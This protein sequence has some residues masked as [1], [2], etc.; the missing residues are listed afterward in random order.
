MSK[1]KETVALSSSALNTELLSSPDPLAKELRHVGTDER[2]PLPKCI[3]NSISNY[4]ENSKSFE[5][6][7]GELLR[8]LNPSYLRTVS[9]N[10]LY[11]TVYD[12]IICK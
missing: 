11:D 5:E 10:E 12:G 4:G 2:Q 6:M 1:Q 9:M 7:Q 8:R 3:D